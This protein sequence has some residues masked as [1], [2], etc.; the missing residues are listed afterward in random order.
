MLRV[1]NVPF[2]LFTWLVLTSSSAL[3][4]IRGDSRGFKNNQFYKL[5]SEL[6][7]K[8]FSIVVQKS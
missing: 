7:L 6:K 1:L 4:K 3:S 8:Q 5:T 2:D